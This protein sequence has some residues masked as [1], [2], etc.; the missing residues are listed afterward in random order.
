MFRVCIYKEFG[1]FQTRAFS[2]LDGLDSL[3][4]IAS[5]VHKLNKRSCD[6]S[7]CYTLSKPISVLGCHVQSRRCYM[8]PI[9][10][11]RR[12]YGT[13][14][15]PCLFRRTSSV[16]I[17][18]QWAHDIRHRAVFTES[19]QACVG[20]INESSMDS[21]NHLFDEPGAP[22]TRR[23]LTSLVTDHQPLRERPCPHRGR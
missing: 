13:L 1:I 12:S 15:F 20:A 21:R 4:D 6:C 8:R 5:I 9:K 19:S 23:T 10:M 14:C 3:F 22:F 7:H 18:P 16:H 17:P 2:V 11:G